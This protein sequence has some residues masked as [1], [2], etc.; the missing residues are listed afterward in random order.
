MTETNVAGKLYFVTGRA[1]WETVFGGHWLAETPKEAIALAQA[2]IR[3]NPHTSEK[4]KA[5]LVITF[6][7]K[8]SSANP[9]TM[10]MNAEYPAR[11]EAA[12]KSE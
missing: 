9:A 8:R 10:A 3:S 2:A 5:E 7:A 4:I 11:R 6:T 1:G 12:S